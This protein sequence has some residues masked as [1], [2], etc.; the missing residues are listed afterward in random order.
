MAERALQQTFC[1]LVW[2]TSLNQPKASDAANI[3]LQVSKDGGSLSNTTNSPTDLGTS[4]I[5]A[6]TLTA[7]EMTADT[8]TIVGTSTTGNVVVEPVLIDTRV[9]ADV[10]KVSGDSVAADNLEAMFDGTGYVDDTAPASRSQVN[11]LSIGSSAISTVAESATITTGSETGTY[12]NTSALD[13]SYHQVSNAAGTTDFYYQFDVGGDGVPV[14]ISWNGY[15]QLNGDSYNVYAYNWVGASWDQV[16]T[17]TAS[18]GV[19]LQSLEFSLVVGHVGTG[20]NLGKVRF[21][22][23]SGTGTDIFTDRVLCSYSVVRRSVGYE[24]GAIWIDTDN[25]TAGTEAYVNG[26]A[27]SPVDTV[28]DAKT[29]ETSLGLRKFESRPGS[30]LTLPSAATDEQWVGNGATLALNGQDL[31]D[32]VFERFSAVS[33]TSTALTNP[34]IFN[35]CYMDTVS[36]GPCYM[37]ESVLR[38]T[39]TL[40]ATG[41]YFFINCRSGVVGSG[42]P[43]IDMGAAVGATN[44][45]V[46]D[47]RGG[48]T[49]N[50][51]AAG[52]VVTLDGIF[53]TVTLNGADAQVEIRG[54]A[55]AVTNNLTGSPTVNDNTI[56]NDTV[57]DAVW[58]EATGDHVT[59]STFGGEVSQ[60]D[61]STDEVSANVTKINSNASAAVRLALS[62]GQIIPGT[63][64]STAFT[65]TTT[66]WESDDIT[67]ATDD[68]FN[69]RIVIFTSGALSGQATDITDY[70]NVGGRGKFTV[71]ALTEA[72]ANDVTF[73]IV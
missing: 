28:A 22:I 40:V 69:G 57:A 31:S 44:L 42:S 33:G 63:V 68:H 4:G 2:D 36:V 47:W 24:N 61:A 1:L 43:T 56:R 17:I 20:A 26:T 54:L 59:A 46:R 48:I 51:L 72:P 53:G 66:A 27:D 50:N 32:S 3:T 58:D 11:N 45:S 18:N 52:D 29:L 23:Q 39:V 55:K 7:A 71:T 62:A 67:E 65:P 30:A 35:L 41:D 70:T 5:I 25:G 6:V 14:S 34:A 37:H 12:T 60:Y 16:G 10:V 73:V 21:R 38:N 64:D 13:A 15:A 8:V 9:S 49:L 19:S